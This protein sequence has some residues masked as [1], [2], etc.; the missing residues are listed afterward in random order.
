MFT[1]DDIETNRKRFLAMGQSYLKLHC[2][3]AIRAKQLGKEPTAIQQI[4]L[5]R[6]SPHVHTEMQFS[7][8][9]EDVSY[10]ATMQ[11]GYKCCRFK[12][13]TY[14][15]PDRWDTLI[16]PCTEMQ[17]DM[18]WERAKVLDGSEYDLKGLLSFAS[19][20]SII[21]PDPDKYWC[22]EVD[23]ELIMA[24]FGYDPDY[25]RPDSFTPTGLFFDTFHRFYQS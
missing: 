12:N 1:N 17:E 2:Y 24:A 21:N 14:T 4:I 16:L 18:A 25:Y 9:H 7:S 15:H 5:L 19:E 8:R 10:S 20:L 6:S 3:N 22:S 11:D 23:A 13:I